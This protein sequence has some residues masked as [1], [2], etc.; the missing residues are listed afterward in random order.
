MTNTMMLFSMTTP[1]KR[2]QV[3]KDIVS[4][5][6]GGCRAFAVNVVDVKVVFAAAV[7]AGVLVTLQG[8]ISVSAEA[9]V[10]FCFFGVLLQAIFVRR[11]PF[12][13]F[14]NL[15]FALAL[16]AAMLGAGLVDK[17]LTAFG[18]VKDSAFR[19]C[20]LIQTHLTKRLNVLLAAVFGFTRFTDPLGAASGGVASTA[21]DTLFGGVG[22][23]RLL[24]RLIHILA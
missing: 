23:K 20:A 6:L 22:H 12:M 5:F 3:F 19:G 2:Q 11:K 14:A 1:A 18:A 17:I 21:N 24:G 10:I 7:L 8:G 13:D 4:M 15:C 9:V 16:G